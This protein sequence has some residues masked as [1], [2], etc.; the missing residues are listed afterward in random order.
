MAYDEK[1]AERIRGLLAKRKGFAEK[2]MF[3]GLCFLLNDKM[4]CGVLKKDLVV[5][6]GPQK[7]EAAL[8]RPHVRPM[9]FTGRPLKGFI[10]VGPAGYSTEKLLANWL[11]QAEK[12]LNTLPKNV[13]SSRKK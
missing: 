1:L 7:F 6:V 11:S 12:Y 9:D 10:Y 13:K 3:G 4:L 8:S 2:K 5:R